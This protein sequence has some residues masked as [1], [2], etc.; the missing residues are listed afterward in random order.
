MGMLS[1]KTGCS[2]FSFSIK[3]VLSQP[4]GILLLLFFF[5]ALPLSAFAQRSAPIAAQSLEELDAQIKEL[6]RQQKELEAKN[7]QKPS[8]QINTRPS[9]P[10]ESR[11]PP[12]RTK[13][14][15]I[16]EE[17]PVPTAEQT[18]TP[19]Q[20]DS[21]TPSIQR[22]GDL[23]ILDQ[24]ITTED[25]APKS[26]SKEIV[27]PPLPEKP[28]QANS[29]AKPTESVTTEKQSAGSL[30]SSLLKIVIIVCF[31]GALLLLVG[32]GIV[33][34]GP[35]IPSLPSFPKRKPKPVEQPSVPDPLA[36]AFFDEPSIS[37]EDSSVPTRHEE[38]FGVPLIDLNDINAQVFSTVSQANWLIREKNFVKSEEILQTHLD[39]LPNNQELIMKLLE[40]HMLSN[41]SIAFNTLANS[42]QQQLAEQTQDWDQVVSWGQTLDPNNPLYAGPKRGEKQLIPDI[43]DD[44]WAEDDVAM[45]RQTPIYAAPSTPPRTAPPTP[46]DPFRSMPAQEDNDPEMTFDQGLAAMR[47][48]MEKITGK[49]ASQPQIDPFSDDV[50]S[51]DASASDEDVFSSLSPSPAST[52]EQQIPVAPAIS[53]PSP[54]QQGAP[55]AQ[56]IPAAP[57]Q[58]IPVEPTFGAFIPSAP[59]AGAAPS[60]A[61]EKL[62]AEPPSIVAPD[63]PLTSVLA[64]QQQK[65]AEGT[66]KPT[67]SESSAPVVSVEPASEPEP[68]KKRELLFDPNTDE[69]TQANMR[70]VESRLELVDAYEDMGDFVGAK[71]LLQEIV[72]IAKNPQQKAI[73]AEKL[74][75][76]A[77]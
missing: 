41:N 37:E 62:K 53:T 20:P 27:I 32:A 15:I 64:T 56:K 42:F 29:S 38:D 4:L 7:R 10:A 75:D 21:G 71:E 65:P 34:W 16:R 45:N 60:P 31:G 22:N 26:N 63:S 30:N 12:A 73:A 5:A 69:R 23:Y 44:P 1:M 70:E 50:W 6:E 40:V 48:E 8:Q 54:A 74:Q 2:F 46:N 11:Q 59:T 51:E 72:K 52:P 39:K 24:V 9:Q 35:S 57:A 43:I 61:P 3:R 13:E 33:W 25:N 66:P 18:E 68:E 17:I 14:V 47:E 49:P 36:S 77:R 67:V 19:L 58:Q 76:L 55:V 28:V